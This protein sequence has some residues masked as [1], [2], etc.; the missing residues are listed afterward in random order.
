MEMCVMGF[1]IQKMIKEAQKMQ[2]KMDNVQGE[3][4]KIQVTGTA[5]GGAV[6]VVCNGKHE[7]IK[8]TIS[9]EA[10]GDAALL[11]D[12][13]LTALKDASK[14][15]ADIAEDKFAAVTNGISI[16]GLK[17]PGF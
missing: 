10:A 2:E 16:P 4:E 5:G 17:F 15:V 14:K 13:V 3:L 1:D 6:S 12:L 11:E 7:F 8:V 9:P